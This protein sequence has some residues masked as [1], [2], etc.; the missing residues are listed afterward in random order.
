M[1]DKILYGIL[2]FAIGAIFT[3]LAWVV[4]DEEETPE[5]CDRKNGVWLSDDNV[6]V[7]PIEEFPTT[8]L[9]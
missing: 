2:I 7:K 3:I 6:C 8:T 5:W 1:H 9:E 4:L